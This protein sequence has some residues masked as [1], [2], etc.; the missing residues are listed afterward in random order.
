[1]CIQSVK[2][3]KFAVFLQLLL[4]LF[5]TGS[6][7]YKRHVVLPVLRECINNA[8]TWL[9]LDFSLFYVTIWTYF[10]DSDLLPSFTLH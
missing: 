2:F 10:I 6:G 7:R 8:E 1:M 3:N 4:C 5:Q 9:F